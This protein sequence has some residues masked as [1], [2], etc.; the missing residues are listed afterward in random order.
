MKIYILD[1]YSHGLVAM[2]ELKEEYH[3][4]HGTDEQEWQ[5]EIEEEG[6]LA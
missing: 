6:Q 1:W 4:L 5:I 3:L 2:D